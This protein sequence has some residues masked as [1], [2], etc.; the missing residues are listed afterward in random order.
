MSVFVVVWHMGVGR[1]SLI[2]SREEYL[3]HSFSLFDFINFHVLLLAVPTFIFISIYLYSQRINNLRSLK[4]RATRLLA[5]L[6]F[7]PIAYIL[8]RGGIS[9][10]FSIFPDSIVDLIYVTLRAG[11]T[12]YYFFVSLLIC[13]CCA[14]FLRKINPKAQLVLFSVSVLSLPLAAKVAQVTD[15]SILAAYW[16]PLNFLPVSIAAIVF[17]R[18]EGQILRNRM[19]FSMLAFILCVLFSVLEWRFLTGSVFFRGNDYAMPAY[20]RSSLVFAVMLIF[21][22]VLGLK[23]KPGKIV[24]FM[25]KYSLGLYC[26]HI[27]FISI[28]SW[29]MEVIPTQFP[30]FFLIGIVL[31]LSYITAVVLERFFLKDNLIT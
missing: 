4:K 16:S 22:L 24:R 25:S 9:G 29:L 31:G 21:G 8:Y 6:V 18:Y 19:V 20:T 26:V 3:N 14:Y 2:F 7:W 1:D 12:I 23:S 11:H 27:F 15:I 30:K 5:L 10:L 17:A 13:L 28:G